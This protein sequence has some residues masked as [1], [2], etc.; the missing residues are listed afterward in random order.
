[1]SA[2]APHPAPVI[3]LSGVSRP[4]EPPKS[5]EL[6]GLLAPQRK[7]LARLMRSEA[8]NRGDFDA[9]IRQLTEVAA[10]LLGVPR[11]S[12]WRYD[13]ARSGLVCVDLYEPMTGSHSSGLELLASQYPRYFRALESER[14]IAAGDARTDPRTAEFTE[15]YLRPLGI[16]AMLDAPVFLR[17]EMMGV[18]C[19]EHVG[20]PRTWELWEELLA[21]TLADFVSMVLEAGERV[22]RERELAEYR[23]HLEQLV[24]QRTKE[25]EER[26]AELRREVAER[27][28]AEAQLRELASRDPLTEAMNRRLFFELA[29]RELARAERAAEPLSLAMIDADHFK[30][31]NDEHGH[32][33]GDQVLRTLVELCRQSLRGTDLLARYGGEEFVVLLPVTELAD[34]ERVMERVRAQISNAS[35]SGGRDGKD[36]VRFTVSIG[37]VSRAPGESLHSLLRRSD[38][39]LYEAKARGRNRVFAR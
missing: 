6:E 36:K 2:S 18:V 19:H 12:V 30:R 5:H 38:E 24:E 29:E 23:E 17:G 15:G 7:L 34:A 10:R 16:G 37:V 13:N 25:I 8:L 21:G 26:N 14:A 1:M 39:A 31:V 28:R 33:M 22:E 4:A 27:Q 32:L 9:A 35:M 3:P 20:P 11:A